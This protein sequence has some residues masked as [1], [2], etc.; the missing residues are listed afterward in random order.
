VEQGPEQEELEP[1]LILAPAQAAAVQQGVAALAAL[2]DKVEGVAALLEQLAPPAAV[3]DP[4]AAAAAVLEPEPVLERRAT[5][6]SKPV[7]LG[8]LPP[9]TR[10]KKKKEN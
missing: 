7:L 3:V 5:R 8:L 9:V 1:L 10:G 6:S 4:M 2:Q